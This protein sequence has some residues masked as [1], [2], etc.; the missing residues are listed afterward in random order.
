MIS[1]N[2]PN[3]LFVPMTPYN[4]N[5]GTGVEVVT[6]KTQQSGDP[7]QYVVQVDPLAA[8]GQDTVPIQDGQPILESNSATPVDPDLAELILK[9]LPDHFSGTDTIELSDESDV[10]LYD[11]SGSLIPASDFTLN[12]ADTS[13]N[14]ELAGLISGDVEIWLQA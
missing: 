5:S 7:T 8:S 14:S 10:R 6:N 12:T 2:P 13:A 9:K 1:D 4:N 11:S 3:R